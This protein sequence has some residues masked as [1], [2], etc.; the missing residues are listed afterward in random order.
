MSAANQNGRAL[1][2]ETDRVT[3]PEPREE[4]HGAPLIKNLQHGQDAEQTQ[5]GKGEPALRAEPWCFLNPN[6]AAAASGAA[7]FIATGD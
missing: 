3:V 5:E 6:W 2:A 1:G 7:V 4:H